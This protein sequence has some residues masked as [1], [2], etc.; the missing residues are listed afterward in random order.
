MGREASRTGAI[1][2]EVLRLLKGR[3]AGAHT[4][5][6]GPKRPDVDRGRICIRRLEQLGSNVAVSPKILGI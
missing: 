2:E 6:D 5:H 1:L 4:K 3:G